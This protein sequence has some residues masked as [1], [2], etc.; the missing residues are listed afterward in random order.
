MSSAPVK[1]L[2]NAFI[3]C[4]V[5][6]SV[7]RQPFVCH[8]DSSS[9]GINANAMPC[10]PV[11]STNTAVARSPPEPLQASAASY[12]LLPTS[13]TIH[14]ELP[15]EPTNFLTPGVTSAERYSREDK[16]N[17]SR[18]HPRCQRWTHRVLVWRHHL[19]CL[20]L[21]RVTLLA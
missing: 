1:Q 13:P 11:L 7:S 10:H 5:V 19:D 18:Y 2:S 6:H 16:H 15:L 9:R 14:A 8:A 3:S 12:H 4:F 20:H 21:L 17:T